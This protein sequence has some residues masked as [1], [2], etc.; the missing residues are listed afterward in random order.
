MGGG[1]SICISDNNASD[2]NLTSNN[3][4]T[5]QRDNNSNLNSHPNDHNSTSVIVP[6]ILIL[7]VG[8]CLILVGLHYKRK[9]PPKFYTLGGLIKSEESGKSFDLH[10]AKDA[11]GDVDKRYLNIQNMSGVN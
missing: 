4:K 3:N 6:L 8:A 7:I 10:L 9:L 2:S 11:E 5:I 1:S